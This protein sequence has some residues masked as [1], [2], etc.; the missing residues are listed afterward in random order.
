M[1]EI[2]SDDGLTQRGK[3]GE[4]EL[5]VRMELDYSLYAKALEYSVGLRGPRLEYYRYIAKTAILV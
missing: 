4:G 5:L 3:L 1:A 2:V